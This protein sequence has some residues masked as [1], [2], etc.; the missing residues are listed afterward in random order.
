MTKTKC[1]ALLIVE[2]MLITL[3]RSH[4]AVCFDIYAS[5]IDENFDF[6]L[7]RSK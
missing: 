2:R 6:P 5:V 7:P 3:K 4:C 1:I